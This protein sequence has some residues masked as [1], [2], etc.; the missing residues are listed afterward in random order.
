MMGYGGRTSS[1]V[2]P[3]QKN[4]DEDV[5]APYL[6]PMSRD[7]L[8]PDHEI[9]KH[10]AKLPHW[11]QDEVMQFVTFRLGDSLPE[12]VIRRWKIDSQLWK[13]TWPPPW[14]PEQQEEYNRRFVYKLERWLDKGVGSCLLQYPGSRSIL[15]SV[16]MHFEGKRVEHHSWVIMP[17][18][19][20]LIFTPRLPLE[21]LVKAW[22][23]TSAR[24]IGLGSI[25]QGNFRDTLIRDSGHFANAVRYVRRNPAKLHPGSYTLWE[26]PRA[27][28]VP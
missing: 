10:G 12:K 7:F 6:L 2:Y 23:G 27:A 5:H 26:G 15:E 25:W 3:E 17:N 18:H 20:H 21:S 1:S 9:E 16:L 28:A 13:S 4:M 22:K 11:K 8:H 14:T 19:V 24:R